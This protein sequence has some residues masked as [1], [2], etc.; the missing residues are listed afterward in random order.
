MVTHTRTSSLFALFPIWT[1]YVSCLVRTIVVYP[2]LMTYIFAMSV[3][4]FSSKW[5]WWHFSHVFIFVLFH[6]RRIHCICVCVHVCFLVG[7][8]AH[9]DNGILFEKLI[10]TAGYLKIF[11]LCLLLLRLRMHVPCKSIFVQI[12]FPF[13]RLSVL[14]SLCVLHIDS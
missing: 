7:L 14:H 2:S 4:L 1:G 12:F 9:M 8:G 11:P 10:Q 6:F 5:L 3:G 13:Y